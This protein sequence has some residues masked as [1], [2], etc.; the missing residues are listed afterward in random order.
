MRSSKAAA[1][2]STGVTNAGQSTEAPPADPSPAPLAT[3]PAPAPAPAT[4][5]VKARKFT[6]LLDAE[7]DARYSRLLD[8][9]RDLVGSVATRQDGNGRARA[10]YDL[11]R[12]DLLRGLLAAADDDPS[13]M[14]EVA[15]KVRHHYGATS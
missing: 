12:A 4:E 15:E 9:L 14:R 13:V 5:R 8:Q 1:A 6:A 10:G 2:W 11:S 3:V 7:T